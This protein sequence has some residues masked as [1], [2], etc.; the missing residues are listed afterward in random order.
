M[1]RKFGGLFG[2]ESA[3]QGNEKPSDTKGAGHHMKIA[4]QKF[5]LARNQQAAVSMLKI[6]GKSLGQRHKQHIIGEEIS[7]TEQ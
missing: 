6:L 7:D 1:S 5:A 4:G 2:S 3:E